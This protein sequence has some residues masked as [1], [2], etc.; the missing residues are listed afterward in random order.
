MSKIYFVVFLILI[1]SL[2]TSAFIMPLP[3]SYGYNK[4]ELIAK[5]VVRAHYNANLVFIL[6]LKDNGA[7]DMGEYNG[8]FLNAISIKG[9]IYYIDYKT[10]SIMKNREEVL[11]MYNMWYGRTSDLKAEM[12]DLKY[13]QPP[14]PMI[15]HYS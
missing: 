7:Y 3:D 8:H 9:K 2:S 12:W 15:W 6:P 14:F 5:D 1:L 10:Q 13:E 4:C 11:E